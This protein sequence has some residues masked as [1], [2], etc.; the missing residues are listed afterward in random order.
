MKGASCTPS[1]ICSAGGEWDTPV[2][3]HPEVAI[4]GFGRIAEKPIV[5]DGEIVEAYLL[6]Y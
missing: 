6:F 1:N 5:R 4:L 3:N 2:I